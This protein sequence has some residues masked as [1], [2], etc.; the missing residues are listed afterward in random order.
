MGATSGRRGRTRTE[1]LMKFGVGQPV[2]RFEDAR[3]ITGHGSYTDDI[4]L[5]HTAHA[6]VLRSPVAHA[7]IRKVDAQAARAMPGVLL[8]LTGEG[9]VI[10]GLGDVPCATPLVNRDGSPRHDTPR[11][12][13]AVPKVRHVGEPVALVVAQTLAQA[14]DAAEAIVVEYN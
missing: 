10:E 11:P 13:L 7:E 5:P 6:Y 9:V 4:D 12:V 14:R 2:R 1:A 8:I 3:L